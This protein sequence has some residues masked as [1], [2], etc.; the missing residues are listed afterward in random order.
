MV[1]EEEGAASL[2]LHPSLSGL[3]LVDPLRLKLMLYH[4]LLLP[5]LGLLNLLTLMLRGIEDELGMGRCEGMLRG[6][7]R[8]RTVLLQRHLDEF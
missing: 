2:V 6:G 8:V 3:R 7:L 4:H 5:I 1:A